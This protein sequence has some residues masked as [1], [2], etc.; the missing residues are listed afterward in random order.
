MYSV[1]LKK[2]KQPRKYVHNTGYRSRKA[3]NTSHN[4]SLAEDKK[5]KKGFWKFWIC[6][7][8]RKR[9]LKLTKHD[10]L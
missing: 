6:E 2:I 10:I 5:K 7:K 4:N 8:D 9:N 3:D 1:H